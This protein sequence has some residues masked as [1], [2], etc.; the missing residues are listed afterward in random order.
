VGL[1]R[2]EE[3]DSDKPILSLLFLI[4]INPADQRPIS[5]GLTCVETESVFINVN[6][7]FR[8]VKLFNNTGSVVPVGL[9]LL[10]SKEILHH[11]PY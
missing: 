6:K 10:I 9:G 3:G 5:R 4:Q 8:E 1:S 11:K 2:C 7:I